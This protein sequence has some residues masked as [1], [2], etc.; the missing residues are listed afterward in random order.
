MSNPVIIIIIIN[1]FYHYLSLF[2]L[3]SIYSFSFL[4]AKAP[5]PAR[6]RR[7]VIRAKRSVFFSHGILLRLS[8]KGLCLDPFR[9]LALEVTPSRES[10]FCRLSSAKNSA[11]RG[12]NQ[13]LVIMHFS[14]LY[15][16]FLD[17]IDLEIMSFFN[18][19]YP[20]KI[21]CKGYDLGT[22]GF[23]YEQKTFL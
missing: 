2:L 1:D 18:H 23:Y 21:K 12:S 11:S 14:P 5:K 16:D 4:I 17:Q 6:A 19:F 8:F 13:S 3:F 15:L 22:G 9:D 7:P 10:S 20:R